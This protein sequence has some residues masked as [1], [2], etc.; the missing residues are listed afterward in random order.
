MAETIR[1][2]RRANDPTFRVS[3]AKEDH[4]VQPSATPGPR[5]P[6]RKTRDSI[7]MAV[8]SEPT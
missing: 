8:A 6:S 2:R 1:F 7:E 5:K 4:Q 3:V